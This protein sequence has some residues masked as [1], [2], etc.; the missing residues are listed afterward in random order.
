MGVNITYMGTKRE[1][2]SLVSS[3]VEC[4]RDGILLDAFSG[5]CSL[6]EEIG[7]KRHIWSNDAQYFASEVAYALFVGREAPIS[8]LSASEAIFP[9]YS[10]HQAKLSNIFEDPLKLEAECQASSDFDRFDAVFQGVDAALRR[11]AQCLIG[12]KYVLFS[13]LY[14]NSYVGA[15]QAI[16]IDS[17]VCSIMKAVHRGTISADQRRWL[18][19]ALGRAILKSSSTTG[20]FAQFLRPKR[21][22][23]RT[24]INQRRRRIWEEWLESIDLLSP[25]GTASWRSQNRV[26]NEDS[27]TLIRRIKRRRVRPSVVYADPPYTDDQYSRFYHLFETLLRYDYPQVSGK[28]RYRR[29]RFQT[30]FSL[31][32][33]VASA[34][35][36]FVRGVAEAGADLILSYPSNGLLLETGENPL[37]IMCKYFPQADRIAGIPHKHSTMG[38]S[39]GKVADSVTEFVYM[40]KQ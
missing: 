20:H 31:R 21:S 4:S 22:S 19:I 11:Q 23:Y 9:A 34:F 33:N 14:P 39:K 17:I 18:L 12:K 15:A 2:V 40:A 26:F 6:G 32:S 3:A 24:F 37:A 16:E 13:R 8:A 5:M 28:G 35:H 7:T 10:T 27:L 1:L 25:V 36:G 29:N 30:P 38:A